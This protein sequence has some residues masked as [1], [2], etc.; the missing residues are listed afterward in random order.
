LT[1]PF[2]NAD[3]LEDSWLGASLEFRKQLA[4]VPR[5]PKQ[6]PPKKTPRRR[7]G[8]HVKR[9]LSPEVLPDTTE[10]SP[11]I[12][13]TVTRSP[14]ERSDVEM[15]S[16]ESSTTCTSYVSPPAHRNASPP[17]PPP[18]V[19]EELSSDEDLMSFNIPEY[20]REVARRQRAGLP[21]PLSCSEVDID[22]RFFLVSQTQT[23][24]DPN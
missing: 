21:S 9:S 1:P 19:P 7:R 4:P 12:P 11:V 22:V 6:T 17:T 8:K 10:A 16:S 3:I 13:P 15:G 18:G 24:Y 2:T 14:S 23:A 5:E 20:N